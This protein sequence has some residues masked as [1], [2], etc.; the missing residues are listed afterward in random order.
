VGF[1]FHLTNIIRPLTLTHDLDIQPININVRLN[2]IHM[3]VKFQ[4]FMTNGS[5]VIAKF[6]IFCQFDLLYL[7]FDFDPKPWPSQVTYQNVHLHEIHRHAKLQVPMTSDWKVI[8]NV[9]VLWQTE[10]QTD[11]Q[12]DRPAKNNMPSDLR[13][14]GIKIKAFIPTKN[15]HI[16][17][18]DADLVKSY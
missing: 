16:I 1:F 15:I 5:K 11:T 8:A 18:T 14:G 3:F 9:K 6:N 2:G 12:T 17:H 13:S 4:V 7:T 10:R